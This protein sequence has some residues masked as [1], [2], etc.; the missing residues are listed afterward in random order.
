MMKLDKEL[1][2]KAHELYSQWN[3][4][5]LIDSLRHAEK[6]SP[7]QAWRQYVDLWEFCMK[8][9]P[10]ANELQEKQRERELAQYYANLTK[11]E[12]MRRARGKTT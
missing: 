9:S 7:Q 10:A 11:F 6:L 2:R 8:L 3:E 5:E 1:Y 4:V 12:S